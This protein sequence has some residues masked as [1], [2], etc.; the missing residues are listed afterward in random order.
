MSNILS[1]VVIPASEQEKA[2]TDLPGFFVAGFS[3]NGSG[4]ATHYISSGY[5]SDEELE[6]ISNTKNWYRSVY[7]RQVDEVLTELSIIAVVTE[8]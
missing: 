8:D 7:F 3:E 6:L 4:P 2:Q 5:F 1:T